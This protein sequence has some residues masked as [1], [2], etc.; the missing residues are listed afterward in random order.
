[1]PLKSAQLDSVKQWIESHSPILSCSG[2]GGRGWAIQ[3]E[4][5]FSLLINPE[6]GQINHHRG[7]PMVAVTCQSCGYTVFFNAIQIG[8]MPKAAKARRQRPADGGA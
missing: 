8:I 4:L 3:N 6:S 5:A 7:Y 1:M 2:C